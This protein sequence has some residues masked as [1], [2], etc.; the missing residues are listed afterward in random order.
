[1]KYNWNAKKGKKWNHTKCSMAK[2]NSGRQ[3]QEQRKREQIENSNKYGR[4]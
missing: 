2:K 1:M 3:K 4:H